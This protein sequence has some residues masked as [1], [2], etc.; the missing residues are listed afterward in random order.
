MTTSE[1]L[2]ALESLAIAV[3]IW[4]ACIDAEAEEDNSEVR[5]LLSVLGVDTDDIG[6]LEEQESLCL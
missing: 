3:G 6:A 2:R 5:R 4:V 1:R